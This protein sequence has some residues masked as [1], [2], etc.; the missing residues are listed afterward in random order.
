[1]KKGYSIAVGTPGRIMDHMARRTLVLDQVRYVVLDEADRMLDMGF[2]D[3]IRDLLKR[4]PKERQTFLL[5]ATMPGPV[6]R[7]AQRYQNEPVHINLSPERPTV[8]SIRQF[9]V[10]VDKEKKLELL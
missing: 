3:D 10:T 9:F 2:R 1:M 4:C 5:S 8:E 7:P 6:L